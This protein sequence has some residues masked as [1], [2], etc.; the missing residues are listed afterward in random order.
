MFLLMPR[1]T[2][3]LEDTLYTGGV[4]RKT[5]LLPDPPTVGPPPA[6]KIE[7]PSVH[8]LIPCIPTGMS[9]ARRHVLLPG[10]YTSTRGYTPLGTPGS[11]V[12]PPKTY[13][14]PCMNTAGPMPPRR[15]GS[16]C[17]VEPGVEEDFHVLEATV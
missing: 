13:S 3:K 6:M 11:V 16:G 15:A 17:S 4:N 9:V 8:G 1:T 14:S 7:L 2:N 12:S 10:L 5:L